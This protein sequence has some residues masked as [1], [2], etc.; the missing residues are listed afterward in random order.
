MAALLASGDFEVT[1]E[2]PASGDVVDRVRQWLAAHQEPGIAL[3]P[4]VAGHSR[5]G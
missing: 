4:N 1:K 5:P 2:I 3:R